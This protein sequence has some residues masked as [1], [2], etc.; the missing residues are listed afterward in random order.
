M[1]RSKVVG[2]LSVLVSLV[3][4]GCG[5]G[6]GGGG[7]SGGSDLTG[8]DNG[9]PAFGTITSDL[10]VTGQTGAV[11]GRVTDEGGQ[12]VGGATVSLSTVASRQA[13]TSPFSTLTN[14]QGVYQFGNLPPGNYS[15]TIQP[16]GSETLVLDTEV[17]PNLVTDNAAVHANADGGGAVTNGRVAGYVISTTGQL[18]AGARVV[19]SGNG[20]EAAAETNATGEFRIVDIPPGRY[21]LRA[22]MDGFEPGQVENLAIEADVTRLYRFVLRPPAA[23]AGRI[24]GLVSSAAG[25]ALPGARIVIR[26]GDSELVVESNSDGRYEA[27]NL[28]A[29]VYRLSCSL[30]GYAAAVF[31]GLAVVAGQ[32]TVRNVTLTP[33]VQYG[34]VVGTVRNAAGVALNNVLVRI[35][36]EGVERSTRT[37]GDGRYSFGELAGGTYRV[38]ATADG[39]LPATSGDIHVVVSQTTEANLTLQTD[40]ATQRGRLVCTVRNEANAALAEATVIITSGDLTRQGLTNAEGRVEFNELPAGSYRIQV[41]RNGYQS[42][43]V[44]GV[45]V[46]GGQTTERSFTLQANVPT[47]GRLV[48]TVSNTSGEQLQ[49][50]LV[51]ATRPGAENVAVTTNSLGRYEFNTLVPG[52]YKLYFQKDGYQATFVENVVVTGGQT[53][54]RNVTM[55][56]N[57][58]TTGRLV[59]TVRNTGGDVLQGVLVTA[60]RTGAANVSATTNALGR[61]EFNELSPGT[62]KVY[63]QK[64]GYQATFVENV[65]VTA[66]QTTEQ[67]ATLTANAP[68]TGRLL[69]TVRNAGDEVLQGVLV[70][71]T[72]PGV[73]N[74]VVT[75][76]AL[77]RFEFNELAAG[78][79]KVYFQKE[80]YQ[81]TFTDN[82]SI[83]AGQTVESN[84]T[85][86]A[87]AG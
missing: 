51:T 66:G 55:T 53:T 45:P 26:S 10:T 86:Q 83:T 42:Q 6:G 79:Y 3:F 17:Q 43:V 36:G 48:G 38:Y 67:N 73:P 58:P 50:V 64:D 22:T 28:A 29:G 57:A 13:G 32:D 40:P 62:Y 9:P 23:R 77:G 8:N 46:T 60:T 27:A 41:A 68:T 12:P 30:A 7:T 14:P 63:F 39:Y 2:A 24:V 70:T 25:Q 49:G 47:V 65:V 84:K 87:N 44:E 75:T 82:V 21:T 11:T 31:E 18:V 80:G 4:A 61:Y 81:A 34:L 15:L 37:N 54:E 85:L 56:A 69:G 19:I 74:V 76:S 52:T 71:A 59:G 72:R 5:G 33:A 35:A 78:T 16:P 1:R 20:F